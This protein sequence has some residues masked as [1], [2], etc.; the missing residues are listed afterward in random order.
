MGD[1]LG[2]HMVSGHVDTLA[3][4]LLN[5]PTQDGFW[6]LRIRVPQKFS[7]YVIQKGSIAISGV[8]LTIALL[9]R[10]ENWLEIM[11]IPH[12]LEMTNLSNLK[13]GEWVEVEFDSQA[14]TVADLLSVMLPTQLKTLITKN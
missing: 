13:V 12:T 1:A 2:G 9:D 7:N 11:L 6:K 3:E 14:K 4:I 10:A 5:E 8:S